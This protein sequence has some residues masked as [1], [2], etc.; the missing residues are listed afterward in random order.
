MVGDCSTTDHHQEQQFT[1]DQPSDVAPPLASLPCTPRESPASLRRSTTFS[2]DKETQ[3]TP[4]PT[5]Q[6]PQ[7]HRYTMLSL[8]LQESNPPPHGTNRVFVLCSAM[9]EGGRSPLEKGRQGSKRQHVCTS[10]SS[11]VS[12]SSVATLNNVSTWE[13]HVEYS[14]NSCCR[15]LVRW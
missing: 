1:V 3:K 12:W 7:S 2:P 8:S 14:T 15:T 11:A 10:P 6:T 4:T 13:S 5:P 9:R